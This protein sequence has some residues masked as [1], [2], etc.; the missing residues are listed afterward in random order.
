MQF[1][2]HLDKPMNAHIKFFAKEFFNS[3][4]NKFVNLIFHKIVNG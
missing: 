1:F 2:A 3:F 4:N